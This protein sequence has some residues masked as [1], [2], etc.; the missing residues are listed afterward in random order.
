MW[1]PCSLLL[2][3]LLL[4]AIGETVVEGDPWARL[5]GKRLALG[6]FLVT[7]GHRIHEDGLSDASTCLEIVFLGIGAGGLVL[8]ASWILLPVAFGIGRRL[9]AVDARGKERA[10]MRRLEREAV[11]R[12]RAADRERARLDREYE[13]TRPERERLANEAAKREE[14]AQRDR[15]TAQRRR[16]DARAACDVLYAL[17]VPEIGERFPREKYE[18]FVRT[19]MMDAHDPAEVERRGAELQALIRQHLS[20]AKPHERTPRSIQDLSAWFLE[21]EARILALGL[22]DEMKETHLLQLRVRYEELAQELF[23]RDAPCDPSASDGTS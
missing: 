16:T 5:W 15:Q 6:V 23:E 18:A 2:L 21:Q 3:M 19:Y 7:V 20:Q 14:T 13:R 11:R 17:H 9:K 8:G 1:D 22:G 4:I 12:Q 10:R